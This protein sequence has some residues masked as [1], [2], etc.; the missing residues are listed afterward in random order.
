[1]GLV[2][3]RLNYLHQSNICQVKMLKDFTFYSVHWLSLLLVFMYFIFFI[4]WVRGVIGKFFILNYQTFEF[5]K[6]SLS[7]LLI[8]CSSLSKF[9]IH[10]QYI[11]KEI[12]NSI[13]EDMN[14]DYSF[15]KVEL[16]CSKKKIFFICFNES[17]IKIMKNAFYFILKTFFVL[18]N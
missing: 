10:F 3:K 15:I 17:P 16:S 8:L 11:T 14:Q 9:E 6:V 12:T 1:M 5:Q 2:L 7:C 13:L 18:K 4:T